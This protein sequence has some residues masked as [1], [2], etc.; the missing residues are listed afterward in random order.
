MKLT[1]VLAAAAAFGLPAIAHAQDAPK[2]KAE[3]C[4]EKMKEA[5]KDCC[6]K[7]G[8]DG[9]DHKGMDHGQMDHGH[10]DH[11]EHGAG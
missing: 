1:T 9:M 10:S 7:D 8:H 11:A 6:D 5:G 2:P 3:C 4:C